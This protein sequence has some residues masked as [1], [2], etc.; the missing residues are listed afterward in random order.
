MEL[1]K[2]G[3]VEKRLKIQSNSE[4]S[5]KAEKCENY[6]YEKLESEQN[7]RDMLPRKSVLEG[8][9]SG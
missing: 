4:E 3:K 8:N 7:E 2:E 5:N 9:S 1:K 6:A